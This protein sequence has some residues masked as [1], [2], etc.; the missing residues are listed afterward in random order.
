MRL[1]LMVFINFLPNC[2][3]WVVF[4]VLIEF[5]VMFFSASIND[6]NVSKL[7]SSAWSTTFWAKW[8]LN[9][10]YGLWWRIC[11]C[12]SVWLTPCS[13]KTD[14]QCLTHSSNL[15]LW[16]NRS[17]KLWLLLNRSNWHSCLKAIEVSSQ[18]LKY[19]SK[20]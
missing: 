3:G 10:T 9:T 16:I 11:V 15:S 1:L 12:H 8:F 18:R 5:F 14:M 6:W 13:L 7:P 19:I 20:Y 17:R 2:G 4:F